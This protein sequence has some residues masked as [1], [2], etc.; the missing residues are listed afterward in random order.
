MERSATPSNK[1]SP[2]TTPTVSSPATKKKKP[3]KPTI[4]KKRKPPV[5]KG[6]GSRPSPHKL[7]QTP[8][9][10]M[11]AKTGGDPLG[12]NEEIMDEEEDEVVSEEEK[13]EDSVCSAGQCIKPT[14]S[15]VNWVQCDTCQLWYHLVCV[16]L[17][18]ESVQYIETYHCFPCKQK[19]ANQSSSSVTTTGSSYLTPL[20]SSSTLPPPLVSS[21]KTA[22]P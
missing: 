3:V 6:R 14:S 21:S 5:T 18:S 16:G 13:T 1:S 12:C 4:D 9:T 7:Q 10:A 22:Q 8:K 20:S 17:T 2:D 11:I 15:E 19:R